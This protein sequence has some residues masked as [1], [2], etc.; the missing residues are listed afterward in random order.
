[1]ATSVAGRSTLLRAMCR[2]STNSSPSSATRRFSLPLP[3]RSSNFVPRLSPT[4]RP[5]PP[6]RLRLVRREVS[7]L[8]PVHS[9]IASASLVS[10]LPTEAT[11]S[12]QDNAIQKQPSF[13]PRVLGMNPLQTSQGGLHVFWGMPE[14][15]VEAHKDEN[16]DTAPQ[17][18]GIYAEKYHDGKGP[19]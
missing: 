11:T 15:V 16:S 18:Y 7:S 8:Q 19:T 4:S 2:A 6:L 1:M 3:P 9:A 14:R 10:K 17:R 12:S 5:P 13:S